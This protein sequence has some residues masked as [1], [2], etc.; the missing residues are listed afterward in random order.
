MQFRPEEAE[1]IKATADQMGISQSA[2]IRRLVMSK[3]LVPGW[4]ARSFDGPDMKVIAMRSSGALKMRSTNPDFFLELLYET[5]EGAA[6]YKV[7]TGMMT[8]MSFLELQNNEI[9]FRELSR[10]RVM[11]GGSHVM[12]EVVRSVE[13]ANLGGQLIWL[14][15]ADRRGDWEPATKPAVG[16]T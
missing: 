11:M 12:W 10:G 8:P 9:M 14:L 2:Y 3:I 15:A 16:T 7:F 13:D 6:A 1:R 5:Q 4:W